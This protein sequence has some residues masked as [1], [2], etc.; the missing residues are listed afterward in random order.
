LSGILIP[1]QSIYARAQQPWLVCLPKT[2]HVNV[3][4]PTYTCRNSTK[5]RKIFVVLQLATFF[6]DRGSTFLCKPTVQ[7]ISTI[8]CQC[9]VVHVARCGTHD[10]PRSTVQFF[11]IFRTV[12]ELNHYLLRLQKA[13]PKNTRK[14]MRSIDPKKTL[15]PKLRGLC[16]SIILRVDTTKE[17]RIITYSDTKKRTPKIQERR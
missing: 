3:E 15:R 1:L 16:G 12:V 8:A 14:K 6:W 10:E 11:C 2:K 17:K 7:F 9:S 13:N 5:T 4:T